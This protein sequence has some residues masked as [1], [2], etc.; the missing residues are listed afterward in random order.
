MRESINL[1][2]I[3][4]CLSGVLMRSGLGGVVFHYG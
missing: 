3:S 2:S 4:L 1:E